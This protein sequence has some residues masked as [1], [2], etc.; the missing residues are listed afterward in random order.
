[1]AR[2][3]GRPAGWLR[4]PFVGRW[5]RSQPMSVRAVLAVWSLALIAAGGGVA[6]ILSSDRPWPAASIALVVVIGLAFVGSGLLARARRPG[7]RTGVLL[8]LVGFSWFGVALGSSDRVAGLDARLRRGRRHRRLLRPPGPRLPV[9]AAGDE[10]RAPRGRG[11]VRV[12][13]GA[14][15][16]VDALRRPA[17]PQVRRLPRERVPDRPRRHARVRAR[18]P[19]AGRDPRRPGR[20]RGHPRPALAGG[21]AAAAA[22][23]RAR[24]PELRGDASSSSSSRT[25]WRRS[26]ASARTSSSGCR[27][28]RCSRFRCRSS[29]G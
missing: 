27:S 14:P 4:V 12:R 16:G 15:A 29:A 3:Y 2:V 28:W 19:D 24:L 11:H 9:G 7:N 17:R 23:A 25:R 10:G 21:V 26:P 13:A 20:R 6:L 1:M 18:A 22:G 5:A 8:M